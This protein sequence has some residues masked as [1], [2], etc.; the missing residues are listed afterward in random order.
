[1]H[2]LVGVAPA[3]EGL[4]AVEV[5]VGTRDRLQGDVDAAG[6]EVG[7]QGA[8]EFDFVVVMLDEVGCEDLHAVLPVPFGGVHCQVGS[9]Q[10]FGGR[11]GGIFGAQDGQPDAH[12][13]RDS[14]VAQ[15]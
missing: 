13:D 7:G 12:P 11:R 9:A 6:G 3:S 14:P 8:A 2:G 5:T 10:H 15:R 4:G 1:M